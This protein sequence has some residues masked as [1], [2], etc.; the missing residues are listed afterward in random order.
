MVLE[1]LTRAIKQEKET[2]GLQ[3]GKGKVKLSVFVNDMIL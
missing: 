1:V 2:K 3:I